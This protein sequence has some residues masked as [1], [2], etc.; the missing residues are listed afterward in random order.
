MDGKCP[1]CGNIVMVLKEDHG[2]HLEID[3]CPECWGLWFDADELRRFYSADDLKKEFLPSRTYKPGSH[4][5]EITT[6]PRRCP[7][8]PVS[9]TRTQVGDIFVDVCPKCTGVWLDDGELDRLTHLYKNTGLRGDERV[10]SQVRAGNE[11][12][13]RVA[14]AVGEVLD[15]LGS[16]FSSIL[17]MGSGK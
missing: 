1:A 8:C 3:C 16:I 4:T 10:T 9:L 14:T 15:T 2:T 6:K 13:P 5:F 17:K 11:V 7:R 12:K